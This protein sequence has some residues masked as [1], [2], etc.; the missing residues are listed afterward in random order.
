MNTTNKSTFRWVR[1]SLYA[2]AI[3]LILATI[4]FSIQADLV[5]A[6]LAIHGR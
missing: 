5:G 6:I 4:H 3:V 2:G 1:Y